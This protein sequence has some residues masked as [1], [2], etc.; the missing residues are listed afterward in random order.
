MQ[1]LFWVLMLQ[2]PWCVCSW[3]AKNGFKKSLKGV[4][5][6]LQSSSTKLK[7]ANTQPVGLGQMEQLRGIRAQ[8][9]ELDGLV[10][11][12]EKQLGSKDKY[13]LR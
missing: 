10:A 8:L 7:P 11:T 5:K 9:A 4:A 1:S 2:M 6:I 13:A 3:A 12:A